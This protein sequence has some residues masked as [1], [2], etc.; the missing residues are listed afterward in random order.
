MSDA[1]SLVPGN[2]TGITNDC[3]FNLK[4][5]SVRSR[6]YRASIPAMN[7]QTFVG[8]N[9]IVAALPC[10]RRNSYLDPTMSYKRFTIYNPDPTAA[11]FITIDNCVSSFF[12]RLDVFHGSNLLETCQSYAPLYS[13]LTDFQM[14]AS[15][16]QGL[17]TMYGF[18]KSS[19]T[20]TSLARSGLNIYGGQSLTFCIPILSGLIG[21][22]AD[23]MVPI[24][25][26]NDDIRLEFSL[27]S[28][29]VA[30][31]YSQ[32][33][34]NVPWIMTAFELELQI[35]ELSDEGQSMVESVTP[36]SQ[37]VY[38][39]GTSWRHYTGVL[40]SG[41][42]GGFSYLLAARFGSLK[43]LLVLPRRN[44]ETNNALAYSNSSRINPQISQY[45]FRAGAFIIPNKVVTLQQG[46]NSGSRT[47]GGYA[48]GY[49]EIV[50]SFHSLNSAWMSSGC[51][52]A[53]YNV[54][55]SADATVGGGSGSTQGLVT[56]GS[57]G[58]NSY[59]NA[60]AIAQEMEV[61]PNRGDIMVSGFNSLNCQIYFEGTINSNVPVGSASYVLDF[62]AQ[63]DSIF[64]IE[65]GLISARY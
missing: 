20:Q 47:T 38:L 4:P 37:P 54:A 27:A 51:D 42:S 30:C 14:T 13:Y 12:D 49:A 8:G 58:A 26:L 46:G 35:V 53:A 23:K 50:K 2:P 34:T 16:K 36:F 44:T 18:N 25:A 59:L 43:T 56:L 24:G 21:L 65:N 9:V 55:D 29:N 15:A 45:F 7:Q 52:A 11:N 5:A 63:Y 10:G 31:V 22:G 40:P 33:A 62:Y 1:S 60:F 64:A 28:N 48:E 32:S 41:S 61:F 39:H 6:S 57:S 17:S 3:L 19:G